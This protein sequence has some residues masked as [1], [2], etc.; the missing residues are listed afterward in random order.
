MFKK[1]GTLIPIISLAL[2]L[3]AIALALYSIFI[4]DSTVTLYR[5]ISVICMFVSFV[6]MILWGYD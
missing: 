2:L 4:Y 1:K 6:I 3:A 5:V